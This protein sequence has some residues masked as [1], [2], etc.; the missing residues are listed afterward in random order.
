MKKKGM[1]MRK[2]ESREKWNDGRRQEGKNKDETLRG[3][4]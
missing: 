3:K 2:G 4:K 1:E